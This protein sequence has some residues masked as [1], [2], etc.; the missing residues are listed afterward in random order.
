MGRLTRKEEKELEV[1]TKEILSASYKNNK[2]WEKL[3]HESATMYRNFCV[4]RDMPKEERAIVSLAETGFST[5]P[6]LYKLSKK[7]CWFERAAAWDQYVDKK[8]QDAYI[9][10]IEEMTKRHAQHSMAIETALMIPVQKLLEK[11]RTNPALLDALT[12]KELL[13]QLN[14]SAEKFS[15]IVDVERKSMGVATE[16]SRV[17]VDTTSGGEPIKPTINIVV[18]GSQSV[19]LKEV[20]K[21]MLHE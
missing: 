18:N 16:M 8:K 6:Y 1:A 5:K 21:G 10:K 14:S 11:F 7:F 13:D 19:L 20:E 3:P 2:L 17:A 15:R 9:K 4:F 12:P